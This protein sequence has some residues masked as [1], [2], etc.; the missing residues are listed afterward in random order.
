MSVA[1]LDGGRPRVYVYDPVDEPIDWLVDQ[2][3]EV[4]LGAPVF[5]P[6][7]S[8]PKVP[9]A[10][11]IAGAAGHHALLG[12]SGALIT[13]EV[14]EGIGTL[15]CVSKLG[16]GYEVV[17]VEAAT[18]L[19]ILVTNTPAH[20]EIGPVAEHTVALMLALTKHLHHYTSAYLADGGWKDPGHMSV[21]MEQVTVGIVGL[22]RIGGSV[23]SRLQGWGC[24]MLATDPVATEPPAGVEL[25]ELP[26]LLADADIVTL[27]APGLRAGAG[28]LLGEA[29]LGLMKRGAL[30]V[31]TA[32]GNLVDQDAVVLRLHDGRLGGAAL[33]VF[34]P[35]P[36]PPDS[37]LLR[38][39]NLI[40]TPHMSAW[41]P[42]LRREMAEM[43]FRNVSD[44][45]HGRVPE[46]VVNPEVLDRAA[47]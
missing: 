27:H 20:G 5:S 47:R 9:A 15:R 40:A 2:G 41:S 7:R 1:D 37:P 4:T 19:G 13:R 39:P 35:E 29:E 21:L 32:R 14:M 38:A 42:S 33:D 8:R 26:A 45:L 44:A 24:R 11:L 16:I 12:A 46:H 10:E 36:P 34:S 30:L 43:A 3:L 31:N 6:G 22:G 17:D 23:A 28:P 18:D 25:V